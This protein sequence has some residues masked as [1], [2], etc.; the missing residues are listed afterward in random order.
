MPDDETRHPAGAHAAAMAEWHASGA[1][2]A[3]TWP[4]KSPAELTFEFV[5]L[6]AEQGGVPLRL[7]ARSC[8]GTGTEWLG[9]WY[10][11]AGT[12]LSA[13]IVRV[14]VEADDSRWSE[15]FDLA[16]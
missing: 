12:D 11:E 4:P 10:F 6:Q 14:T 1:A 16:A 13:G 3:G 9:Q 8:G 15:S 2:D 7:T 5:R